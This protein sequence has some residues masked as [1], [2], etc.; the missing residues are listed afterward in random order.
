[1][2]E[3]STLARSDAM[4][5]PF[6]RRRAAGLALADSAGDV[7]RASCAMARRFQRG[8]K[9]IAFGNGGASVDAEHIA[10]EFVHPVIVGTRAL[11][12]IALTNDV[13]TLTAVAAREGWIEAYA[14]QLRYLGAPEDVAVGISADG[15][16]R[17]VLRALEAARD[18]GLL[19]IAL[20]GG[21]RG[22]IAASAA[23]D[24]PLV[25]RSDDPQV[26]REIQVTTYHILWELVQIFLDQPP[27]LEPASPR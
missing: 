21:D 3:R 11:P 7:A 5:A 22:A 14:Y 10:V 12:A 20:T 2:A 17:N 9:L 1:M 19:T 6:E 4:L 24:H 13:A 15:Q 25:A 23:V 16:C 27:D 26:V 18:L 8:G